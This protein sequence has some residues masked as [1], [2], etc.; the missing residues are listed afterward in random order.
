MQITETPMTRDE[1]FSLVQ[2]FQRYSDLQARKI[3][4]AAEEA[5]ERGLQQ[6]LQHQLFIHGSELLGSWITM[7]RE[8]QPLIGALSGLMSRIAASQ[9]FLAEAADAQRAKLAVEEKK[10]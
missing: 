4:T 1:G 5:E 8:Y 3:K 2:A 7:I 10:A 6:H 9:Q